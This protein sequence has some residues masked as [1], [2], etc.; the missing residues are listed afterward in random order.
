MFVQLLIR[1]LTRDALDTPL[2]ILIATATVV[3]VSDVLAIEQRLV[4]PLVDNVVSKA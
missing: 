2:L 1:T 4:Y 3:E